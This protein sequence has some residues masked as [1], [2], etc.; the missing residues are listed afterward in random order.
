MKKTFPYR[1]RVLILLYFFTLITYLDRTCISLVGVRIKKEFSLTNEQFGW[2]LGAFALA[3]A[4]FEIPSGIVGDRIGQRKVFIRIVLWWSLFTS[5]TGFANGLL[6][7]IFIRFLF[8]IGES[9]AYP[10]SSAVVARWFPA[11]ETGKSISV[12]SMG[13]NTGAALAPLIVIPLAVSF[14]WRMPFFVNG[15]LGV[16]WVIVC[17]A[18]FRNFPSEMKGITKKEQCFIENNRKFKNKLHRLKWK[19]VF[20][21]QSIWA[22][23][24]MFFCS[25]CGNYFFI[26]WMPVYL[27]EGR[28]FSE[29]EMKMI[30][31]AIFIPGFMGALLA[32][33]FNDWLVKKRGL[34]FGRRLVGI[35]SFAMTGML[36]F[37]TAITTNNNLAVVCLI[38]AHFFYMPSVITS[39][40]A[41]V[42]IGGENA[43]TVA[44]IMNFFGQMGSFFLAIYFG[45]MVDMSHGFT[46]PLFILSVVLVIGGLLW[47][48]I[49]PTRQINIET[50][51]YTERE[52]K[53]VGN[54]QA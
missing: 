1:Y 49:N 14:G 24:I 32:G 18:W 28:H 27:Q 7:L 33:I 17:F 42:D 31:S 50:A 36:I 4:L 35:I 21:S 15:L 39:F 9:G 26:A 48:A 47:L 51:G 20:R 52:L 53:T 54:L 5:L 2:V 34:I 11:K 12:L 3:Y 6:S 10:T 8:G 29:G 13:A 43:G 38:T 44:G 40:S 37:V 41:C 23:S 30:T 16:L 45:K 46:T 19:K 22:L 25:Q